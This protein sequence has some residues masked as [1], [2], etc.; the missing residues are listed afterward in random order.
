VIDRRPEELA[1]V[2]AKQRGHRHH[3]RQAV[4]D[5]ASSSRTL[6]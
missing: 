3:K 5:I 6:H 1:G 4:S 2:Y